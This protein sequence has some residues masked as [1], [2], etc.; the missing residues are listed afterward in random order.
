MVSEVVEN[1]SQMRF[2]L[3]VGDAVAIAYFKIE[4]PIY[5]ASHGGAGGTY[6]TRHWFEVGTRCLR[7]GP[8]Q[9]KK[10]NRQMPIHVVLRD[11]S[12]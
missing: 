3:A 6:G 10:S 11:A 12:S 9:W 2:E 4:D 5:L 7:G 1:P 8:R